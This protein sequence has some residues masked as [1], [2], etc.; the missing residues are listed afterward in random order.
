MVFS[1][2]YDDGITGFAESGIV[3]P[4]FFFFCKSWRCAVPSSFL[5]S[6]RVMDSAMSSNA[7]SAPQAQKQVNEA[8]SEY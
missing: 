8:N 6:I 4:F 2:K 7:V 5:L 3:W 1:S